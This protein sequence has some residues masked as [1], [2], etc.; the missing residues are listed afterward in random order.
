[1]QIDTHQ[2]LVEPDDAESEPVGTI[3]QTAEFPVLREYHLRQ[4]AQLAPE[5][6]RAIVQDP[7]A[8]TAA[9]RAIKR[10]TDA[11]LKTR[12]APADRRYTPPMT[13]RPVDPEE[14]VEADAA[15]LPAAWTGIADLVLTSPP[16]GL[17]MP[18]TNN[19]PDPSDY[20]LY[21]ELR[22]GWCAE[23]H[24]ITNPEHG[25]ACVNVPID[26]A[27]RTGRNHQEISP[28]LIYAD[29]L[30]DLLATGFQYRATI[31]WWDNNGGLGTGRGTPDPSAIPT[32]APAEAIIVVYRGQSWKRIQDDP[33]DHDLGHDDWLALAGPRGCWTFPGASDLCHPAPFPEELVRRCL[34]LYTYRG[35]LVIDP[36]CGR[37][38]TPAV[39]VGLG[40]RIRASDLSRDYI[41][42]SRQRVAAARVEIHP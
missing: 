5:V 40:R 37:G 16:Y 3:V 38:T 28:R 39:A 27:G 24:R 20:S 41:D 42:L 34:R 17:D 18:Y 4:I 23:L 8:P 22:R 25:R 19:V 31:L 13:V 2:T 15:A 12:A 32:Y 1:V 26:V 11:T 10:A 35:D 7:H 30:H 33:R 6:A 36:F 14:L 9:L 21:S 29:W